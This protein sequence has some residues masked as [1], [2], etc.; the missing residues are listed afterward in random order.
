[1]NS[2][3]QNIV[4]LKSHSRPERASTCQS[5]S[6]RTQC[7]ASG[8]ESGIQPT[9]RVIQAGKSVY[10]AGDTFDGIYIVR[11]GF[12]KSYSIDTDGVMQ[13]TGFHLPGEFVGMDG[14]ENGSYGDH[15]EALDTTSVCKLPLALFSQALGDPKNSATATGAHNSLMLTLVRLMS[16]AIS[17]DRRMFFTL[18]KMSARRRMGMFLKELSERMAQSGYSASEFVLC[19]SRTDIANYLCLALETVS[20]LVTQL[21]AEGTIAIDRRHIRLLDMDALVRDDFAQE[22]MRKAG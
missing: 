12:L 4:V 17:G 20:R 11:S 7:P 22:K 19:M 9:Q 10:E 18:G 5:C 16:K 6:K 15:V 13:V 8:I 1:M 21:H 14:I 2:A 3:V